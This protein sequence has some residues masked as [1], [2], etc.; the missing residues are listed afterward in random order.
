MGK[1]P[2]LSPALPAIVRECAVGFRHPVCVLALLDGVP[3]IFRCTEQLGGEPFGHRLFVALARRGNDPA[4]AERLTPRRAYL[5]R[6]LI[7]GA[8]DAAR[9]HLDRRHDIVQRLLEYA[10]RVAARLALDH[11][12]RAIDDA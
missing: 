1:F 6:H 10:D 11:L 2:S 8:A 4:D 7:R 3:P 9:A 5:D 12:E